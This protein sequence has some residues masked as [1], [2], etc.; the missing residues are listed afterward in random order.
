MHVNYNT[1]MDVNLDIITKLLRYNILT[2]TTAAGSGH[3]TSSL[4]AVE[5]MSVLFFGGLFRQDLKNPHALNNDRFVLSKGHASPLLYSLYQAAGAVSRE[6]LM[7]LRQL[8]SD[9]EGHPTPH[10]KYADV[11]SGSLGQGLSVGLGMAL[12][13]RHIYGKGSPRVFVLMGDSEAAEGQVWEAM[14]LAAHYKTGNLYGFID[15]NRL[16]QRGETLL[17]WD[18]DTYAQRVES[19]GWNAVVIHDGHNLDEIEKAYTSHITDGSDKPTMFIVKTVKGK[20]VSLFENKDGWHGK[21]LPEEKLEDALREL[22]DVDLNLVAPIAEPTIA[23]APQSAMKPPAPVVSDYAPGANVATR[24]AYGD[25]LVEIG[26]ENPHVVVLDAE[27]SNST[28]AD[29]FGKQ[30]PSRFFEM[31]IEEQ[32]MVS[33]AVGMSKVGLVPYVSTFAAFMTRAFDQ[34]RMAQY[35]LANIKLCGSHAGVSI[36]EDGASQMGLED[37]AMMRSILDS[38]V[39]YPSDAESALKLTHVLLNHNG[40]GY[41]RTARPKTPIIYGPKEKFVIGGSKILR[42][43]PK[44]TAVIFT[45]GITVHEAINAYEALKNEGIMVSVVDLYSVK[46]ADE[47]TIVKMARSAGNVLVVEDH[48]PAGAL[49]EAVSAVLAARNVQIKSFNH[50]C[51]KKIPHSGSSEELLKDHGIDAGAI[52]GLMRNSKIKL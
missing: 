36:G 23:P 45:A 8:T 10:F 13:L 12:G 14:E 4:S 2:S 35:S 6:E 1:F 34:I 26:K 18:V 40:I 38:V 5:M 43:S 39:L 21:P 3:A 49:G 51:V 16:G 17:G 7:T 41:I 50:L 19:F 9:L 31:Y 15:V 11:A 22:G 47:Q 48:Y 20:G 42:K 44:D 33:V 29:K 24:E 25:A 46:P 28:F 27:T 52:I 37:I 30:F 32:N